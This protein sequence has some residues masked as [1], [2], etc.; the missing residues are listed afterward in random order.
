MSLT[1]LFLILFLAVHLIGN[2]QL[3]TDPSGKAFNIYA[4][5]MGTNAFIQVVAKGNFFFILLHIFTSIL[6]TRKNRQARPVGYAKSGA[7][8]NSTWASRNM[9]AL[10]TLILIFLVVHLKG[11]WYE[12]KFGSLPTATYDGV[13]VGD[14]YAIVDAAYAEWWYMAFYVICMG[15]LA[16][17]LIHGFQSAFQTLGVNHKKYTPAIKFLGVVFAIVVPALFALIPI[18]MFANNV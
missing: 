18:V 8:T 13:E 9:G 1:G 17:H 16:F 7:S 2:L 15:I 5:F 10:G 11:F 4:H 3:I 6:L 12:S 14:L